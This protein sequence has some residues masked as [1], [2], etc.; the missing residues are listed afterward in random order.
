MVVSPQPAGGGSTLWCASPKTIPVIVLMSS[1]ILWTKARKITKYLLITHG[2]GW[3][4]LKY[5]NRNRGPFAYPPPWYSL[6]CI[7]SARYQADSVYCEWNKKGR[8]IRRFLTKRHI[9]YIVLIA[10]PCWW[11]VQC[12]LPR[13]TMYQVNWKQLQTKQ[14]TKGENVKILALA[15][16]YFSLWLSQNKHF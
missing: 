10:Y 6:F 4:E 2:S 16:F 1:L 3:T 12:T 14:K 15:L 13:K 11:S 7:L 5:L 9:L 8:Y